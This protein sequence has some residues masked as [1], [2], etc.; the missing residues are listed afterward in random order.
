MGLKQP[1]AQVD[2]AVIKPA[3]PPTIKTKAARSHSGKGNSGQRTVNANVRG[4]VKLELPNFVRDTFYCELLYTSR[5][6]NR[7]SHPRIGARIGRVFHL[8]G[9]SFRRRRGRG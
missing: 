5:E 3:K 6:T 1:P 8:F 7:A 9:D 4:E 2:E